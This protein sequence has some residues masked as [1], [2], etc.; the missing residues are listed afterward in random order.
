MEAFLVTVP[1]GWRGLVPRLHYS[2]TCL[3]LVRV[4]L[5]WRVKISW[6]LGRQRD[7]V[8]STSDLER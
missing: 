7:G 5:R 1:D 4:S 6:L 8:P 2:Y 3:V